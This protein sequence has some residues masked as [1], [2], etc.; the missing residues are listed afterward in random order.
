[1]RILWIQMACAATLIM[2]PVVA[3]AEAT[4][5][6]TFQS[7]IRKYSDDSSFV[8]KA[9]RQCVCVTDDN[10]NDERMAGVVIST[11]VTGADGLRRVQVRCFVR[12]FNVAGSNS[13]SEACS[14]TWVLLR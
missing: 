1:M 5:E 13:T 3:R 7:K 6:E 10:S 2:L 11:F 4:D 12:R 9:R 14:S 8:T